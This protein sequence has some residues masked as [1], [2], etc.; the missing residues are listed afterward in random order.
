MSSSKGIDFGL[1]QKP[2]THFTCQKLLPLRTLTFK[3]STHK[4]V[5]KSKFATKAVETITSTDLCG[6]L[7]FKY[8][9]TDNH[10]L[11]FNTLLNRKCGNSD[12]CALLE[13]VKCEN[14]FAYSNLCLNVLSAT[15][16]RKNIIEARIHL[17]IRLIVTTIYS[18]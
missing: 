11:I 15:A 18:L 12:L 4:K 8:E 7:F 1:S 16:N 2:I 17:C 9:R 6:P 13:D 14:S 10:V 3:T 5:N